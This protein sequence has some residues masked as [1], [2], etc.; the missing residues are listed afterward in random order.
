[1]IN[2]ELGSTENWASWTNKLG[3]TS[4]SD[5]G[6]ASGL[7]PLFLLGLTSRS[8]VVALV[9]LG[10]R[11]GLNEGL[12]PEA[13]SRPALHS[14]PGPECLAVHASALHSPATGLARQAQTGGPSTENRA[15]RSTENEG[16][17]RAPRLGLPEG[18][19]AGT[20]PA[21]SARGRAAWPADR[22]TFVL[23]RKGGK[24]SSRSIAW[25]LWAGGWRLAVRPLA[26]QAERPFDFAPE[27]RC[28][29]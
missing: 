6:T 19:P 11:G 3:L 1:M 21:T 12:S 28:K 27:G 15:C 20:L 2:N 5:A 10:G 18:G 23:R 14:T 9:A 29:R 17:L 25:A 26:R 4:R 24:L 8:D 22:R 7:K 13:A 16:A